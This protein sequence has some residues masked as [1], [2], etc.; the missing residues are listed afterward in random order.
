[1]DFMQNM[2]DWHHKKKKIE[3]EFLKIFSFFLKKKLKIKK[4]I[5]KRVLF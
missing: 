1:M 3:N 4:K 2:L 5:I